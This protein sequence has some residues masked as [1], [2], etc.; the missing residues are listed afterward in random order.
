MP[1]Q[2]LQV[3]VL[4]GMEAHSSTAAFGLQS[5]SPGVVPS[6]VVPPAHVVEQAEAHWTSS[7]G[8]DG[9][10]QQNWPVGQSL[11]SSHSS[12]AMVQ[13]CVGSASHCSSVSNSGGRPSQQYWVP[14]VHVALPQ[15][16]PGPVEEVGTHVPEE[17]QVSAWSP[18]QSLGLVHAVP[19]RPQQVWFGPSQLT[20]P[21]AQQPTAEVGPQPAPTPPQALQT[22]PSQSVPGQQV[23]DELHAPPAAVHVASQLPPLQLVPVLHPTHAPPPAPQ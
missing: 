21:S 2:A 12:V 5:R 22:E 14:T 4:P 20:V 8:W 19:W 18:Q 9:T 17:P 15:V 6:P 11:S 7:S 13:S 10:A 3:P 1:I 23:D 16:M